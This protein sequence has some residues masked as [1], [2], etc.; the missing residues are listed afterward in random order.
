M[1]IGISQRL[2][3]N[4]SYAELREALSIEWGALFNAEFK[5]FLPLPLCVEIPF[6][7]YENVLKGV[8][9]SGG[10][11]LSVFNDLRQNQ[12]RDNYEAQILTHCA[13]LNIPVLAICRGAQFMAH[14]FGS[15]ILS[16]QNHIGAHLVCDSQGRE[17]SVNSF[18]NYAIMNLG[19]DLE[20]LARAQDNTIEAFR[21]KT[22]PFF[23]LMWHI[24]RKNG[25]ENKAILESFKKEIFIYSQTKCNENIA[26]VSLD[27]F[28]GFLPCNPLGQARNCENR[29]DS[30]IEQLSAQNPAKV[31]KR[32]TQGVKK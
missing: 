9:L 1:F 10:N 22:L 30:S 27:N 21:H 24:E 6:S 3:C 26:E 31:P 29:T 23:A 13:N 16:Y 2:V 28:V 19:K 15:E 8:I 17:F 32:Q 7:R 5:D 18:H 14:F 4:E 11:D 25:L 20:C 12:I